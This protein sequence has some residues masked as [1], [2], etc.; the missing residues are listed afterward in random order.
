MDMDDDSERL[1]QVYSVAVRE[2][3]KSF[4]QADVC[5][6]RGE[7]Y[8]L[9][10]AFIWVFFMAEDLLPLLRAPTTRREAVAIFAFFCVLL[11]RLDGHWWMQGWGRHLVAHAY[12]LLDEEGRL[13]IRWAVDEIGWVPPPAAER[14]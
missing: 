3:K 12:D 6:A 11:H 10:D 1:S 9:I 4:R 13:W 14:L 8:E 7:T 2:L 5:R